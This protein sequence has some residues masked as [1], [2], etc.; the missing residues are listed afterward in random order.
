MSTHRVV[1]V[2]DVHK[3]VAWYKG[4]QAGRSPVDPKAIIDL[5]FVRG[6]PACPLGDCL[7][8]RS[9]INAGDCP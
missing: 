3:Q 1:D 2:G 4:L 8:A 9:R 6:I 5:G 7:T